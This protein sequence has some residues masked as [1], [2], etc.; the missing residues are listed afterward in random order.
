MMMGGRRPGTGER[1]QQRPGNKGFS[2]DAAVPSPTGELRV[3]S[4]QSTGEF[5]GA[6]LSRSS[7]IRLHPLPVHRP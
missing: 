7:S 3:G 6:A 2:G 5:K 4:A 1:G